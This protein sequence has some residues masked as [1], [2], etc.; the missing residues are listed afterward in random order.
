MMRG[1][2]WHENAQMPIRLCA[3]PAAARSE[4]ETASAGKVGMKVRR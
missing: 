1:Y 3:A 4:R 2:W